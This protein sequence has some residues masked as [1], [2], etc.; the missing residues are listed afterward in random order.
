MVKFVSVQATRLATRGC[1]FALFSLIFG[2]IFLPASGQE[3]GAAPVKEQTFLNALTAA[4]LNNPTLHAA[5]AQLRATDETVSQALSNWRPEITITADKGYSDIENT[6]NS[7]TTRDQIRQ[8][9]SV[10]INITQPLYRGG[11]TLA[12]TREAENAVR[13]EGARLLATEQNV[14]LDAIT[15]FMDVFRDEAVLKFNIN[16]EQVL[17]Q[18]LEASRI[19]FQAG[20]ITLTDVHQAEA[21]LAGAT[22]DHTR[23]EGNLEV[24]RAAY[25]SVIGEPAPGGLEVPD[26]STDLPDDKASALK[27][28]AKMN[29]TVISAEFDRDAA[30]DNANEVSGELLPDISLTADLSRNFESLGEEGRLTTAEIKLNLSVPIF[31][32]GVVFSR[33]REARQVAATRQ[34]TI[35][36]QRRQAVESAT[37]AW[38][39]LHT[40]RSQ[41]KSFKVQI[42]ANTVALKGVQEEL[43]VG[44]R[45]V[46]DVLDAEQELL[47]ARVS[48]VRARRD[49]AVSF[50]QLKA[51]MGQLTARDLNLPVKL[52]DPGEHYRE[53]RDKWIGGRSTGDLK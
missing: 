22:A 1:R 11:Q 17:R 50:Y 47:N 15:A 24:S 10:G 19:R 45:T 7:G 34:F 48:H 31:Q 3:G 53:V 18:Q 35:D 8:P 43:R 12:A 16:N 27:I 40:A 36:Q 49:E 52:Y 46:L 21:R 4:Y 29:P 41:I 39:A 37:G 6:L 38:E 30:R 2:V 5:R 44:S 28:A 9:E 14:L 20:E 25:L 13:S 23:A 33:L 26:L 32:Q 42:E 51:A